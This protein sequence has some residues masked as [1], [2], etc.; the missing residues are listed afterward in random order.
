MAKSHAP[1]NQWIREQEAR[2]GIGSAGKPVHL[3]TVTVMLPSMAAVTRVAQ[4]A[5]DAKITADPA[6]DAMCARTDAMLAEI[7]EGCNESLHPLRRAI[8]TRAAR[9]PHVMTND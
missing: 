4:A 9:M 7:I 8:S 6:Y 1:I 3:P 5:A 2:L